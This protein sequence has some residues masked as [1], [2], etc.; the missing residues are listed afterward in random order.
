MANVIGSESFMPHLEGWLH[1]A[2]Q[3]N[4]EYLTVNRA[5]IPLVFRNYTRKLYRCMIVDDEFIERI[6]S[7]KVVLDKHTSW[8]KDERIAQKST[9][10][11][12][13]TF[14]N[15]NRH[16]I[17]VS[18]IFPQRDQI[19]DI[20]AFI[21]FM[22]IKQLGVLGYDSKLLD[23]ASKEKSVIISKGISISRTDY[24]FI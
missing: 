9:D 8:T 5:G 24:Q 1:K 19:F 13:Y 12:L 2:E 21:S 16:K 7:G 14:G 20:D 15:N 11:S 22:G 23:I 6:K 3:R 17:L 4:A 10:D 18:K